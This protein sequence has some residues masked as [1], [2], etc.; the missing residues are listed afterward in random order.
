LFGLDRIQARNDLVGRHRQW[1]RVAVAG[2][3]ERLETEPASA[4]DS[5]QVLGGRESLS[6]C[7]DVHSWNCRPHLSKMQAVCLSDI[8]RTSQESVCKLGV[9]G[10]FSA[11]ETLKANL[12]RI[13]YDW[14]D[15]ENRGRR[16]VSAFA[17]ALAA[18]RKTVERAL[19][20]EIELQLDSV[21]YLAEKLKMQPWELLHPQPGAT[22]LSPR[23]IEIA[24][25]FD[26]V[27][28]E[29]DRARYYATIKQLLQFD[30]SGVAG[31]PNGSVPPSGSP[32]AGPQTPPSEGP[33]APPPRRA[34]ETSP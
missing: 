28:D 1:G 8:S 3:V 18:N 5:A 14:A 9:M 15:R 20:G 16:V 13:F 34:L 25:L 24:S 12:T 19:G 7:F 27:R 17:R 2:P 26:Q 32:P 22:S 29:R 30:N 23:A 10:N 21:T 6:E 11:K 4:A 33:S 31:S